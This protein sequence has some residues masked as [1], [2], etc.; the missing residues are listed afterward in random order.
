MCVP[1]GAFRAPAARA[2]RAPVEII[3]ARAVPLGGRAP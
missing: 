2:G 1:T 3:T